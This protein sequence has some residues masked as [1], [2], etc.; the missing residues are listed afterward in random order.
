MSQD[1]HVKSTIL[2][3]LQLIGKE[4]ELA[5]HVWVGGIYEVEKVALIPI[6]R[7]KVRKTPK[8]VRFTQ[9]LSPEIS[10]ERNDLELAVTA[11]LVVHNRVASVVSLSLRRRIRV[12]PA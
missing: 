4:P 7:L 8:T 2:C 1:P 9:V 3:I 11:P 12:D 5:A 10:V 6:P